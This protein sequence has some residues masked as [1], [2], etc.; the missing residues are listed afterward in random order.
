[1]RLTR[2]SLVTFALRVGGSALAEE[3][4]GHWTQ[5]RA[6]RQSR[7]IPDASPRQKPPRTGRRG[8][9]KDGRDGVWKWNVVGSIERCYEDWPVRQTGHAGF[10]RLECSTD[11]NSYH[12]GAT[13][14]ESLTSAG[15][16]EPRY[17][18]RKLSA[19]SSGATCT[20]KLIRTSGFPLPLGLWP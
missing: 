6:P 3:A 16:N 7:L 4:C 20:L 14:G 17:L 8:S 10:V 11:A 5:A 18:C 15:R 9:L 19:R 12:S 1:M 13:A 2:E